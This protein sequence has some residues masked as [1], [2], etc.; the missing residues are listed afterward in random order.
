MT[1]KE[2][3]IKKDSPTSNGT[4]NNSTNNFTTTKLKKQVEMSDIVDSQTRFILADS[5]DE[6]EL[7]VVL[8]MSREDNIGNYTLAELAKETLNLLNDIIF[9][10]NYE[11]DKAIQAKRSVKGTKK[12]YKLNSLTAVRA[13]HLVSNYENIKMVCTPDSIDNLK[14]KGVIAH[15]V[16]EGY[17][18]GT[19]EEID[20]GLIH[21]WALDI[22]FG[23]TQSWKREFAQAIND[24]ASMRENRIVENEDSNLIFM[25]NCIFNYKTKERI[26]FSPEYVTLRKHRTNLPVLR[27]PM[28][29]HTKPDGTVLSLMDFLEEL[30]PYDGGIELLIKLSGAVL[31]NKHNWRNMV[32]LYNATG[33]NGK[34]TFLDFL[35]ALV[36]TGTMTSSLSMLAGS[37][38]AGRFALSNLVGTALITCE[39]S[40]S[41]AYI[42]DNSRLKSIIS[43]D[44]ISIERKGEAMFDYRPHAL[45]VCAANDIPKTKDKGQAWLNRNI[46]VPFTGQFK[47]KTDDKSIREQWVKSEEF[48]EYMAYLA[49][50]DTEDYYELPE[51]DEALQ[52]KSQYITEN[53]PV[54]EFYRE[55]VFNVACDF[56]PNDLLW[57]DYLDWI[58]ENRPSTQKMSKISFIKRINEVI[59]A[60]NKWFQPVGTNG[61]GLLVD[62]RKW[63]FSLTDACHFNFNGKTRP[64][65][66]ER[67][68]V[69]TKMWQYCQ[70][71]NT[72]PTELKEQHRYEQVCEDLGLT[73]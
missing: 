43:H 26:D 27:P 13:A 57:V 62:Y 58:E 44:T 65:T 21:Q 24:I 3:D 29:L 37:G 15:Y 71:K 4:T 1:D 33:N 51:P 52:L 69:R 54:V 61:K 6:L 47:G 66:R 9:V 14:A 10:N 53:D 31:R 50:I 55:F 49:L 19:F 73:Y 30:V 34:S 28:P 60:D 18:R 63:K 40:D 39:D 8:Y 11:I 23:G 17:K 32:T 46:Y 36:G 7:L 56:I 22:V 20:D 70:D 42:R 64:L 41:G 5:R 45:I 12:F 2:K 67:G 25:N 72:N 68:I 59:K 16:R 48:C 38:D 35:K